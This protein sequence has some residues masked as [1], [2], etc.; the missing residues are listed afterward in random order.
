M[1]TNIRFKHR[2]LSLLLCLCMML[3]TMPAWLSAVTPQAEAGSNTVT[4]RTYVNNSDVYTYNEGN[5]YFPASNERKKLYN[6]AS[7]SNNYTPVFDRI[8][9]SDDW[10][11]KVSVCVDGFNYQTGVEGQYCN[12]TSGQSVYNV[13]SGMTHIGFYGWANPESVGV[14]S[15]VAT[16]VILLDGEEIHLSGGSTSCFSPHNHGLKDYNFNAFVHYDSALCSYYAYARRFNIC[17]DF[18]TFYK[19]SERKYYNHELYLILVTESGHSF[20]INH[21]FSGQ[22]DRP[23]ILQTCNDP[24][25]YID[26]DSKTPYRVNGVNVYT[27]GGSDTGYDLAF[28]GD[29]PYMM[30]PNGAKPVF[31]DSTKGQYYY[32][33]KV[34]VSSTFTN[35]S[36]TY[37]ASSDTYSFSYTATFGYAALDNTPQVKIYQKGST[38]ALLTLDPATPNEGTYTFSGSLSRINT[39][40]SDTFTAKLILESNVF[41]TLDWSPT[42]YTIT[43]KSDGFN[44][45]KKYYQA[46]DLTLYPALNRTGYTFRKWQV[47]KADGSWERGTEYDERQYIGDGMTGNP[48]LTADWKIHTYTVNY[49]GNGETGGSTDSSSHTYDTEK[50]LTTNGFT[51]DG[52]TFAGWNTKDDGTGDSY[53]DKESVENLTAVD[54]DT[55]TLYAQ[56]KINTYT[57]TFDLDGGEMKDGSTKDY[58][59]KDSLILPTPTKNGWTF[60]GWYVPI[61]GGHNWTED[62][63]GT[64]TSVEGKYGNVTLKASWTM[65]SYTITLEPNGGTVQGGNLTL[66]YYVNDNTTTLPTPTRDGWT[67]IGWKPNATVGSWDASTTYKGGTSVKGNYGTVTLVAQW[68]ANTYTVI[69]NPN[70][71][72]STGTMDNQQFTYDDPGQSL[73]PNAFTRP[74]YSFA[75]WATTQNGEMKYPDQADTPNVTK[76]KDAK[77]TLYAV[78]TPVEYTITFDPNGGSDVDGDNKLK[79]TIES[80]QNL[81]IPKRNGYTFSGWDVVIPDG[82]WEPE[83]TYADNGKDCPVKG[84]HGNVKLIARWDVEKSKVTFDENGGSPDAKDFVDYTVNTTITM[85]SITKVGYDFKGWKV[86]KVNGSADANYTYGGWKVGETYD[87]EQTISGKYGAVTLQAQWTPI[88]YT[89]TFKYEGDQ[90]KNEDN[91]SSGTYSIESQISLPEN[92]YKYGYQF[93]EWKV[94]TASGNWTEGETFHTAPAAGKWGNITLTAVWLKHGVSIRYIADGNGQVKT[95]AGNTYEHVENVEVENGQMQSGGCTPVAEKHARFVGWYYKV[96]ENYKPVITGRTPVD[97]NGNKIKGVSGW[98]DTDGTFYPDVY[99]TEDADETE[100]FTFYALFDRDIY[101]VT[102]I[103]A[104]D[105]S[106]LTVTIPDGKTP[107]KDSAGEKIEDVTVKKGESK[108]IEIYLGDCELA[109]TAT[110][111]QNS[112]EPEANEAS[113]VIESD[114]TAIIAYQPST[115]VYALPIDTRYSQRNGSLL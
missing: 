111:V 115:K 68:K 87:A 61:T 27:V 64:K 3:G 82:N 51:K 72:N 24:A 66:G 34:T 42:E 37:D 62:L 88:Q 41:D 26:R 63:Y 48:I 54:G 78:W 47:T 69:Y 92:M 60:N 113:A 2:A 105:N 99:H 81:P 44:D 58:N 110:E 77:V 11:G 18:F 112:T 89:V 97:E 32:T 17:F 86:I 33:S 98:I 70:C 93:V 31:L 53:D 100:S 102:I 94:T 7:N 14:G 10:G 65:A 83:G 55:V 107:M 109:V 57:I 76:E 114:V 1:K 35:D 29:I 28:K 91:E 12:F 36:F 106:D 5:Y 90:D 15:P 95:P 13:S 49:D 6:T 75:G 25:P 80:T 40:G 8:S 85:P 9:L 4:V 74:G 20:S 103:N 71:T 50:A 108:K 73:T 45:T 39:D 67:F 30:N 79:Y 52:Y 21:M 16:V 84:M 19:N 96:G 43:Y 23:I 104:T 22:A 56:W 38:N 101:T 59:I 46:T